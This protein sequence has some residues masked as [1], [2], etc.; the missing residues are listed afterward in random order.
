M[1][2]ECAYNKHETIRL[3]NVNNRRTLLTCQ[4]KRLVEVADRLDIWR[5][6]T[7]CDK[8][9]FYQINNLSTWNVVL[10]AKAREYGFTGVGLCVCLCVCVCLWPR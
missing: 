8:S 4:R 6:T 10:P 9:A 2:T 7:Q 5:N 3:Q 1:K